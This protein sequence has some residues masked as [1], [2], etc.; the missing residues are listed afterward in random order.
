MKRAII[1]ALALLA[2]ACAG[3]RAEHGMDTV[4]DSDYGRL[5]P[6]QT[7]GVEDARQAEMQAR[8]E[9]SRAKLRLTD[10]QHEDEL[11]K[12]DQTAADSD[13]KR[14]EAETKIGADSN[15]P[16]Q[17]A[18]AQELTETAELHRR[19]A[20]AHLSY[21]KKLID[22]RKAAVDAAQ[23]RLEVAT[24]Q[25]NLAKLKALQA[26]QIPAAGK[27]DM[28]A[29]TNRVTSAQ[30]DYDSSVHK[31][32]TLEAESTSAEQTWKDLNQQ[33]QARASGANRG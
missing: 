2:G 12:A 16:G 8:D 28:A 5:Q 33:L 18:R 15:D 9:L 4:S 32:Q 30:R 25:V 24:A 11:A 17:K 14:A 7:Q 20:D 27:Y 3:G 23:K 22:S 10:T 19:A 13:K 26:A 1:G 21:A 6:G 31:A 29:M